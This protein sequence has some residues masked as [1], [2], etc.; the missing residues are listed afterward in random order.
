MKNEMEHETFWTLFTSLPHWEFEIFLMFVFDVL[1]GILIWPAVR[2]SM[3][4]H[5][6]DDE[7]I[8]DL[9]KAVEKLNGR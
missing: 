8:R 5:K 1:V 3:T 7:R 4:H 6:S 2:R 9:E